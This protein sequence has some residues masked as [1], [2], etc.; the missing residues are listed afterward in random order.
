MQQQPLGHN[1]IWLEQ[2]WL[3]GYL[4]SL[5]SDLHSMFFFSAKVLVMEQGEI[6][7]L[8]IH[9]NLK[10]NTEYKSVALNLAQG[11]EHDTSS[12][13]MRCSQL[14]VSGCTTKVKTITKEDACS[15][16]V[17]EMSLWRASY[18]MYQSKYI[19]QING[20]LWCTR[21]EAESSQLSV[22]GLTWILVLAWIWIWIS[23]E[24]TKS[25]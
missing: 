20:N 16:E 15:A 24:I 21:R 2:H 22:P 25:A 5:D 17:E 6:I 23:A 9:K 3:K 14:D 12:L 10:S 13:L 4:F 11:E 7:L 18:V 19:A 1:Y 8:W